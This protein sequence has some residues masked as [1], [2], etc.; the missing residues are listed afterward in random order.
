M[1]QPSPNRLTVVA[2]IALVVVLLT[3]AAIAGMRWWRDAHRADLER[4]LS[5]APAESMRFS[6]TDWADVRREVGVDLD[7]S[8]SGAEVEE[9]LVAGFDADLTSTS[10]MVDSAAALQ[11]RFG[12]APAIVEWE[13]LSQADAGS[14]ATMG[15]PESMDVEA[16]ADTLEELGFERPSSETGVWR[17]TRICSPT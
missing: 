11:S 15:L 2:G 6:W 4:A 17:G 14:V 13:L 7:G 16:L 12:F 5:F 3:V 8:S 9:F 10:S 1:S